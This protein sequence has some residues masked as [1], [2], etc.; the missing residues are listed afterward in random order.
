MGNEPTG[1]GPVTATIAQRIDPAC[2][3]A[4]EALL[5]GLYEEV[6]DFKGFVGRQVIKS[7]AGPHLDYTF[8]LHFD[9][10]ASLRRWE[11]SP[12]RL[13]WVGRMSSLAE[14]TTPLRILTGLESWFTMSVGQAIVPPPRH[15]MAVVTWLALFPLITLLAY[16]LEFLGDDLPLVA[17]AFLSTLAAVLLMTYV[18][19][20]RMTRLFARWLYGP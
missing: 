20:P 16:A 17:H 2:E 11:R 19:M 4:Y 10:E 6:K 18:V 8:L 3:P 13:K 14:R 9:C 15:K 5:A 1:G 7:A 12:K